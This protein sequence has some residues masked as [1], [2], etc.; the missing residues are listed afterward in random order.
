MREGDGMVPL[1]Q[2]TKDSILDDKIFEEIFD[3]EDPIYQARL[4]LSLEDRAEEL[5]V[6]TKFV[7]LLNAYKKAQKEMARKSTRDMSLV[8]SWTNFDGPYDRMQCRSWIATEDGICLYNPNTGQT[9]IM[10]CYHPI[11]PVERLKNLETGEEQIKLAYKRRGVWDEI[12]VPKTMVTSATKIV[13]LSGRGIAVTSENAKYLVRYLADVENSNEDAI[14]VQYSSSKLGWIR[15][16]FM[17]YD[18]DIVF[19]GDSRFGQVFESIEAV[20]SRMAWYE[21]IKA[22][23][24]KGR[25]EI[26]FMLA[27]SFASVLVNLVGGLPFFT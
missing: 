16:G 15:D 14:N 23:R 12:I 7:K 27:A 17:P 20:G 9:D 13:A 10:A 5:G 21:H 25:L 18:T 3:Q 1:N 6:K 19:D 8:E 24:A 2:L 26:K 11:L 4:M 22:L